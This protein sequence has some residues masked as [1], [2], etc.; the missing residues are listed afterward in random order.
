MNRTAFSLH[1]N[2]ISLNSVSPIDNEAYYR[3]VN[4]ERAEEITL[5]NNLTVHND[6]KKYRIMF[7]GFIPDAKLRS[8]DWGLLN[9]NPAD[10]AYAVANYTAMQIRADQ[11]I[12]TKQL[13]KIKQPLE[14]LSTQI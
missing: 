3:F 9:L 8:L 4:T 11:Y 2:P 6:P 13:T 12:S 14:A 1:G 10:R 5:M 7:N